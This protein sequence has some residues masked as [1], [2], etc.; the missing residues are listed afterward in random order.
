MNLQLDPVEIKVLA[1]KINQTVSQLENVDTIIYDTRNDLARVQNLKDLAG[2]SRWA[3]KFVFLPLKITFKRDFVCRKR[4]ENVLKSAK[5][6]VQSLD[7]A[8]AAQ[9][10]AEEAIKQSTEDISLA[11]ADLDEVNFERT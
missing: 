10:K 3:R 6:V 7:E 11:R 5:D 4:A 9:I 8:S 1:D 2:N